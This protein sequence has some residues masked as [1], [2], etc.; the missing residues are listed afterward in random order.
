VVLLTLPVR[1]VRSSLPAQTRHARSLEVSVTV[2]RLWAR[3]G[4]RQAECEEQIVATAGLAG[5]P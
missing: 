4:Q 1:V 2:G 5:L 3:Y